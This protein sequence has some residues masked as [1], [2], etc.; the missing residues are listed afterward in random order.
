MT[1]L[2]IKYGNIVLSTTIGLLTKVS[3]RSM[4]ATGDPDR[5]VTGTDRITNSPVRAG[6]G[7]PLHRLEPV[8]VRWLTT[9]HSVY[10]HAEATERRVMDS[11]TQPKE[12]TFR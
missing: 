10:N 5:P 9:M 3:Y 4:V 1:Q 8:P 6:T 12:H 7:E 2:L 11:I